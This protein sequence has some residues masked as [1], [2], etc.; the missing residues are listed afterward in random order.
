MRRNV[1]PYDSHAGIVGVELLAGKK[2]RSC[3]SDIN[4]EVGTSTP[5][6]HLF[7]TQHMCICMNN[8]FVQ[9]AKNSARN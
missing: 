1:R 6:P 8:F 4:A 3:L 5:G 2:I 7:L 9:N